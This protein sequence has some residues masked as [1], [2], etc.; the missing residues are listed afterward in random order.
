[1]ANA[2]GIKLR[3][4]LSHA[5]GLPGFLDRPE[6]MKMMD[7]KTLWVMRTIGYRIRQHA[8]KSLKIKPYRAKKGAKVRARMK[9]SGRVVY[10]PAAEG[11]IRRGTAEFM[12]V[13]SS[14]PAGKPP[15]AHEK[16]G[17]RR[18]YYSWDSA[19]QAE[20][21][22][23]VLFG[24]Q[25]AGKSVAQLHEEGG[26]ATINGTIGKYPPR[27]FMRPALAAKLPD[28]PALWKMA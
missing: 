13:S 28:L 26:T 19:K 14:S 27:P 21:V 22:G 8:R 15:F 17:L 1:M 18:I 2:Y 16:E 10:G 20:V 3:W 9:A 11:A 12:A 6:I 24:K 7:R 23:P 4:G 5:K 25:P